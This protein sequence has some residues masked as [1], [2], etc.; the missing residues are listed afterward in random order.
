MSGKKYCYDYP[1]P[2]LAADSI[3]FSYDKNIL[4]VLL[5]ERKYPPFEGQ[6]AIPGGFVNIDEEIDAAAYRE[7]KE[8][9][10]ITDV[11]LMQFTT[12]GTVG[13]DPRGRII[14][15]FFIGIADYDKCNVRAG[16]DAKNAKWLP[17]NDLPKLAFD[18]QEIISD[19]VSYLLKSVG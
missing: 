1:R 18:H 12:I 7:L 4:K 8:E 17:A 10:G 19:A 16:D 3:I 11:E 5:I 2:A 15:V 14:S 13:R 6:W 9:T